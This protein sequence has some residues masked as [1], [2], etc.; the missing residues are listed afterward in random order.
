[1]N[2]SK[3]ISPDDSKMSLPGKSLGNGKSTDKK[4]AA[5]LGKF[6]GR[7]GGTFKVQYC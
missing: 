3:Q 6:V 5:T 1:M 7:Q 2:I 4:P